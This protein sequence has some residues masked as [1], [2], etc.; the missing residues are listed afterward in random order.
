VRNI[1]SSAHGL[2]L[3][4]ECKGQSRIAIDIYAPFLCIMYVQ[5]FYDRGSR[6]LHDR[7]PAVCLD[8][9]V[10]NWTFVGQ[11]IGSIETVEVNGSQCLHSV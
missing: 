5:T 9:V 11:M 4:S 1:A 10:N 6:M 8:C 7:L 3:H 2:I